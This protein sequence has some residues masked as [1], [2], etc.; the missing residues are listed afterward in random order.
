MSCPVTAVATA[1][2]RGTVHGIAAAW[3]WTWLTA[4]PVAFAAAFTDAPLVRRLV[5]LLARP[6][7][8]A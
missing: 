1:R 8:P 4:W 6:A 5:A 3:I 7:V 2:T